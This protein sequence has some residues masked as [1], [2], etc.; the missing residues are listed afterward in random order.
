VIKEWKSN[1]YFSINERKC[2]KK[3]SAMA[4]LDSW[5]SD[6]AWVSGPPSVLSPFD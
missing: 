2:G 3:C 4:G 5:K 1:T 6:D